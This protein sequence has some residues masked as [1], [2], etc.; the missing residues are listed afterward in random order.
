[1]AIVIMG[2]RDD[3]LSPFAGVRHVHVPRWTEE[4]LAELLDSSALSRR[5]ARRGA[6]ARSRACAVQHAAAGRSH[7]WRGVDVRNPTQGGHGF[8]RKADSIPMIADSG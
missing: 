6:A 3:S 1:M 7:Q 4:E 8:R 2:A 5:S